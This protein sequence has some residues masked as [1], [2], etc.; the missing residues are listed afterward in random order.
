LYE[1]TA[2]GLRDFDISGM[3]ME[4]PLL[5]L[6]DR[7]GFPPT[8]WDTDVSNP[9]GSAFWDDR[10]G[11]REKE[12]ISTPALWINGW[13]DFDV[14]ET[15]DQ[16]AN[17]LANAP[18]RFVARNQFIVLGPGSHCE[19]FYG[20]SKRVGDYETG[21]TPYY[22]IA[23]LRL[24]WFDRILKNDASALRNFPHVHYF[25]F[26]KNEWR[27]AEQLPLPGTREKSYFLRSGVRGANSRFG[28]GV[29]S[30]QPSNEEGVDK[31]TY[32]PA[33]PVPTLGGNICCAATF[34]LKTGMMDQRSIEA[35]NDVLVFTSP[36]LTRDLTIVG[37]IKV[38]L[39]VSSDAPDTDFSAKLVDVY[40]D[41]RA[42]IL[43]D[44]IQRARYRDGYSRPVMMKANESYPLT[45]DLQAFANYFPAGHRIRLEVS[46]SNFPRFDRNLNTGGSNY[47]ETTFVTAQNS[48]HFGP[49]TPSRLI[50][51][52]V[53]P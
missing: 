40:P 30:E 17:A 25:L 41:G 48:V 31:F 36:P 12:K 49:D 38:S 18:D 3:A 8:D 32:D 16:Y 11:V 37:Q 22:D 42:L 9:P 24:A 4:L 35:R 51:P 13:N 19:S 43:V 46:S 23:A 53:G 21:D 10:D 28:D 14:G 34:H 15:I 27:T 6:L 50:I 39:F 33:D 29:L 5:G 52:E 45:I 7:H 1:T 20:G 47:D 44:G 26:G 2:V